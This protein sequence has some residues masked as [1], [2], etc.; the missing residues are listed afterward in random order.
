MESRATGAR[1]EP[2][3]SGRSE[4]IRLWDF[5]GYGK[6][7]TATAVSAF[8]THVTALALQVLVVVTLHASATEVGVINASRWVPY[9]CFG[10]LAGVLADRSRRRPIL[11][12]TDLGR[13]GLL[14]LIP[15]LAVV[16]WLTIP[17]LAAFLVVFGV[18][19]LLND[20]AYQSFVPALV[21]PAA[22]TRAN[23]RL[24]Q[25]A[26]VARTTGPAL[27]GGLVT[28]LGAPL[29]VLVDAASYLGS[30]LILATVRTDE[31]PTPRGSGASAGRSGLWAELREGVAWVYR[32]PMLAPYAVT[33]HVWFVFNSALFTV[34]VPYVL[35]DLRI[36][37]LGLGVAY[38]AAG[39]G[40]VLGNAVSARAGRGLGV[41][42]TVVTAQCLFPVA[43][44]AVVLSP[45]GSVACG[46]V[47]AG[48]FLFGV[49]VG[50]GSPNELSYRQAVTPGRL[51][52]R[53]N[54]T[55]RSMNWGLTAVGAPLGGLAADVIGYRPTLWIGIVGVAGTAVALALS[56]FRH[57]RIS[58]AL[59]EPGRD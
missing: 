34:F 33:S 11:V 25:G 44:L 4:A 37:A 3:G 55:I 48:Q 28:V 30:G 32:H 29:A 59:P 14:A 26:S 18:L 46:M 20:A 23:A 36:G 5:P 39:V 2:A 43:F 24:D 15:V 12:G 13:A 38:A 40:G 9:L 17:L 45:A 16:D 57:A 6:L 41:G 10:L 56:R 47:A 52:G 7:W 42:W 8:G 49:A 50:L 19:S 27:A 22:L 1:A 35:R 21:D 54:A 31:P 51:Q 58:D 53:M